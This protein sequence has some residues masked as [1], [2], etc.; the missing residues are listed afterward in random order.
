MLEIYLNLIPI[1]Y[2]NQEKVFDIC[3][4]TNDNKL[5]NKQIKRKHLFNLFFTV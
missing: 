1:K 4:Q 2:K 5:N 3:H